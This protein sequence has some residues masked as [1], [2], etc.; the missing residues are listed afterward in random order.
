M[1]RRAP[2]RF[3]TTV[4]FTDIVRSTEIASELGDR[5]WR[6]LLARH[7]AIVR[8]QLRRF[9]GREVDTAGDGFFAI[10]EQP[11]SAIRCACALSDATPELGIQIRAGLHTG[12]V[13]ATREDVR[14]IAVHVGARIMSKATGGEVLVSSTTRDL[15]AG[16]GI[17]LADHGLRELKGVEGSWQLALVTSVDGEVRPPPL[18]EEEA[19]ERRLAIEPLPLLRR[20]GPRLALGAAALLTVAIAGALVLATRGG[21]APPPA[22]PH[23]Q[24]PPPDSA[25]QIDPAS[26]AILRTVP[27]VV[28]VTGGGNPRIAIGEGGVWV[29]S[30]SL[31]HLDPETG[32]IRASITHVGDA[33]PGTSLSVAVGYR[34]VWVPGGSGIEGGARSLLY[35]VDPATDERLRTTHLS[36]LAIATDVAAGEG[37]AWVSFTDGA[38]ARIDPGDG[39]ELQHIDVGGS[40]DAVAAGEGSVWVLD[41]VDSL[42]TRVD[43]ASGEPAAEIKVSSNARYIATGEGGLWVL[44]TFTGTVQLI[45]AETDETLPAIGIAD[46]LNGIAV[47]LGAVWVADGGGSIYRVDP[48]TS[49]VTAI[50]VG[51]PLTA[52][53]VDEDT[54]TLWVTVGEAG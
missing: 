14:G 53:G 54:S 43:P 3:L 1:P 29:R 25:L 15:V 39:A 4:L 28:S 11:G 34:T 51:A 40:L 44:D 35:R 31:L 19:K 37:D 42:V 45:D 2:E 46:D 41:S 8:A 13:E 33:L 30:L 7:H 9:G 22:E 48:V 47:G 50:R 21:T 52:I 16:S 24:T 38:L 12:E 5:R 49:E 36:P 20:R 10:F 17:G 18:D 23:T 26:G 27:D 6:E 32:E